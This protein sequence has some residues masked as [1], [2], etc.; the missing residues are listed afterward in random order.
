MNRRAPAI[1][2]FLSSQGGLYV[3]KDE[4]MVGYALMV[5]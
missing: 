2:A 3:V 4:E 1:R 5:S